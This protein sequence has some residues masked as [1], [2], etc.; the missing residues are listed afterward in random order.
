[1]NGHLFSL[2][3]IRLVLAGGRR[4]RRTRSKG[5]ETVTDLLFYSSRENDMESEPQKDGT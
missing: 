5:I 1:M 4:R 2:D 3:V